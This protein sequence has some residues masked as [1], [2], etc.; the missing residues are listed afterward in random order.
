MPNAENS[1]VVKQSAQG[2]LW[3]G[4]HELRFNCSDD[5][6]N[7]DLCNIFSYCAPLLGRRI[8][9]FK[10]LIDLAQWRPLAGL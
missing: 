5:V 1:A 2:V 3:I 8:R 6:C 10:E 9:D 4:E 7:G